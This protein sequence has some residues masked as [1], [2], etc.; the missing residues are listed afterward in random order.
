MPVLRDTQDDLIHKTTLTTNICDI[1][2]I[3]GCKSH[4]PCIVLSAQIFLIKVLP[5]SDII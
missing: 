5:V 4:V 1:M 3:N 2:C